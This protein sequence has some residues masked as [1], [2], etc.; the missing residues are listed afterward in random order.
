MRIVAPLSPLHALSFLP[1]VRVG[2]G[3][4]EN[5]TVPAAAHLV[6]TPVQSSAAYLAQTIAQQMMVE[7]LPPAYHRTAAY[8]PRPSPAFEGLN[9]REIA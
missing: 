2:Q 6:V 9:F 1:R 3:H 8:L 7:P 5:A 4:E